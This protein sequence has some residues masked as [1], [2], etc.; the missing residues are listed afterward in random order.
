VHTDADGAAERLLAA[1]AEADRLGSI[2][3]GLLL[4]S[5]AEA[6]T[7]QRIVVDLAAVAHTRIDQ[8]APLGDELGITIEYRGPA[9]APVWAVDTAPEQVIDNY[10]D[11]AIA[12]SA[13][14][15]TITVTL[16]VDGTATN[17]H[18]LDR[19]PGLSTDGYDRAFDR[20]WRAESDNGGNG[21]GLAI[22]AQL[23]RASRGDVALRPRAGGGVDAFARFETASTMPSDPARP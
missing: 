2:I 14:G 17:A 16:D 15:D 18:V 12:V 4:L 21:L 1:E 20:F 11:N 13:R 10:I 19:G 7:A 6:H 23:A 9:S 5:R 22:V 3:E 8:W